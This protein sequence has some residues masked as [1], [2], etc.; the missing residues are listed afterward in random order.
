MFFLLKPKLNT[1]KQETSQR[2]PVLSPRKKM[3]LTLVQTREAVTIYFSVFLRTI[4][5]LVFFCKEC[6]Q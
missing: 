5:L 6:G 2:L 1:L 4:T 3:M